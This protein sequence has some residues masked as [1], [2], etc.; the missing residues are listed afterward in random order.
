MAMD[1]MRIFTA[2]YRARALIA[3]TQMAAARK[4]TTAKDFS[5]LRIS[6]ILFWVHLSGG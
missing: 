4:F 6:P 3:K 5:Q 2:S 1:C